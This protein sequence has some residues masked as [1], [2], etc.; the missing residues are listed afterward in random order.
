MTKSACYLAIGM[1]LLLVAC[2]APINQDTLLNKK[3]K[4]MLK[5]MSLYRSFSNATESQLLSA[6]QEANEL[7]A[8]L[9]YPNSGYSFWKVQKLEVGSFQ[10][11]LQGSWPGEEAYDIIHTSEEFKAFARKYETLFE[12]EGGDYEYFRFERLNL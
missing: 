4:N 6:I 10:Y 9:G 2:Q 11:L 12:R 7:I 5:T 3:N 8:G 1:L